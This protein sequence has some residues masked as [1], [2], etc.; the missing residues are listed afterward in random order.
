M[1]RKLWLL[2]LGMTALVALPLAVN[3]RAHLRDDALSNTALAHAVLRH[4]IP[5]PDPYLAGQPLRYH[6]GYNALVAG[7]S[8][9]AGARPLTV[10]VLLAPLGL[11]VALVAM[12]RLVRA[13]GGGEWAAAL[14]VVLTVVGLNGWGWV[15]FA[16]RWLAG[17]FR[18]AGVLGLE[19]TR[20]YPLLVR[21]YD[22]RLAFFVSKALVVTS[23]IWTLAL[24][25]V[26]LTG[27]LR[28][29]RGDGWRHGAVMA[30][31]LAGAGYANLLVG[32]AL[33]ALVGVGLAASAWLHRGAGQRE[34]KRRALAGLGFLVVPAA[35]VLP[36]AL[37]TVGGAAAGEHLVTP[38]LPDGR[39]LRGFGVGLLPLWACVAVAGRPRRWGREDA[40]LALMAAGFGAGY[41]FTRVP[42][43]VQVKYV[44]VMAM[45]L[46]AYVARRVPGVGRRR[47]WALWLLAASA[48]PTTALGLVEQA[49]APDE[50]GVTEG[51]AETF[52]WIARHT[53]PDTVV[54][55][56]G[57]ADHR[58][59]LGRATLVPVLAHRDLYVPDR[60]GFHRAGQYDQAV[61]DHRTE[62]MDRLYGR[63]EVVPV[64]EE[65]AAEMGRPVV[66]I[67]WVQLSE[68]SD[69]RVRLL[70]DAG[71]LR[72]WALR[73]V[74]WLDDGTE[75]GGTGG[76]SGWRV[77]APP[78]VGKK[79]R[80]LATVAPTRG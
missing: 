80:R 12:A 19:A 55:Y 22:M 51:E 50:V 45:V 11:A 76:A 72:L 56:R 65:V 31:A 54:V 6:W 46:A 37:S 74:S 3:P 25:P 5:P 48:V 41:L 47:R 79:R 62:Q 21:G 14:A 33:A 27:V 49:R 69:P 32:G 70:H 64:L 43:D 13:M 15:F 36:Y 20:F 75:G 73:P 8:A 38:A 34:A 78:A 1:T 18:L 29:L 10:F 53:P 60:K 67:T 57:P 4:G 44:F 16:G 30:V 59:S 23:Y 42:D 63:G 39:H 7:L 40:W 52:D 35:L 77:P 71:G 9:L 58:G 61:W 2:T 68:I 26:A 24:V 66:L 17:E 28:L